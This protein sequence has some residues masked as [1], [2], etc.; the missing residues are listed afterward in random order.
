MYGHFLLVIC[1]F[2]LVSYNL[3]QENEQSQLFC[4]RK[5][6]L[7][8]TNDERA[9]TNVT[10]LMSLSERVILFREMLKVQSYFEFGSGGSTEIACQI[11]SLQYATVDNSFE[12]LSSLVSNSSCLQNAINN[13]RLLAQYID[14]GSIGDFGNPTGSNT[15]LW[16]TY[17]TAILNHPGPR[18]Q[19]VL[20]DGRFRVASAMTTLLAVDSNTKIFFHDFLNRPQYYRILNYVDV[21]DCVETLVILKRKA[22]INWMELMKDIEY[23]AID[24]Q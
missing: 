1:L 23:Y 15:S 13:G 3:C 9:I 7:D 6:L 16:H 2:C 14:I 10:M 4:N 20:I 12:F 11:P 18:P 8:I 24:F 19:L 5:D 17:P 22:T 21:I